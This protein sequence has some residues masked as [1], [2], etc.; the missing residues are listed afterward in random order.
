MKMVVVEEVINIDSYYA[1]G[2]S[3][4]KSIGPNK[5]TRD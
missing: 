2:R 5:P 4:A 1:V 3:E